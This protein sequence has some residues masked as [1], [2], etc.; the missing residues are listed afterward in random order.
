MQAQAVVFTDR[1][2][3]EFQEVTVPEPGPREVVVRVR[4]S[5]ISNGTEG[6]FLRGERIAG[7]TPYRPGDPWPFPQVAGY[8][9]VGT[10]EWVGP[11]VSDLSVG[12]WVFATVSRVEGMFFPFG[13]H[14]SPAVT[15][16]SQIWKLPP[17]L[18]PLA[19]SG[20]VLT[21]VGYNCGTRPPVTPGE[22]AVVIGDGLVGHWT[23]QTLYWR[24]ARV[25]LVG[26]HEDRL[27]RFPEG[28]RRHRVNIRRTDWAKAVQAL[29]PEGVAI[30]V[31]TV[32][33]VPA[34]EACYPLLRHNGHIVSAG[35]YG[36]AGQ[37]DIQPMRARELTLY[38]P[39][40][41]AR[42]RMD[43]TLGL[44]ASGHLQTEP[45]ITHHFPASQAAAA[46]RLIL[47]RTEPVL[48]VILDW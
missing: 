48:G 8:Q 32:G 41:W 9:K 29:A 35:F 34:V 19:A 12:E 46:W 10:V 28:E 18:S 7:D 25:I 20:L 27:A 21:Q 37:I 22:A 1:G 3:V 47:E 13:G 45:L 2:Q 16:R 31:D 5:W 26:K 40:G 14:V 44:I 39:A 24:G 43:A 4:H 42:N 15:D 23:A 33:S 11:E 36:T 6:S 38:T 30:V 17:G